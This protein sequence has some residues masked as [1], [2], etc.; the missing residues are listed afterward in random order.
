MTLVRK[1]ARPMLASVFL[2]SGVDALRAPEPR[3]PS[4]E[5]VATPK[6]LKIPYLPE[7]P[8]QLV[9]INGAAQV[10]AGTLLGMGRVPRLAALVLIASLV[11]TTVAGHRFWEHD[12]VTERAKQRTQFLKN[13][14]LVGGLLLAAVDTEGK[15]SLGW[16]TR[17]LFSGSRRKALGAVA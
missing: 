17:N 8:V 1:I 13:A 9:R 15:P 5:P 4:A 7:D 12:D 10:A 16:R 6:A 2:S 11:P 14:G 3:A